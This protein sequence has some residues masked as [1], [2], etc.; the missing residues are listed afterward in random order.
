MSVQKKIVKS[1]LRSFKCEF[2]WQ[3]S[4]QFSALLFEPFKCNLVSNDFLLLTF[5]VTQVLFYIWKGVTLIL[6]VTNEDVH[7]GT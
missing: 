7:Y 3:S 2:T 4:L 5:V 6:G 1:T